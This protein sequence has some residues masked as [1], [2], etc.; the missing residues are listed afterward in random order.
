MNVI[1]TDLEEE[2]KEYQISY[3]FNNYFQD[4]TPSSS[5]NPNNNPAISN[6]NPTTSTHY[7]SNTV[8]TSLTSNVFPTDHS[9][10]HKKV[11]KKKRKK[12]KRMSSEEEEP[13]LL[14]KIDNSILNNIGEWRNSSAAVRVH[15]RNFLSPQ[16]QQSPIDVEHLPHLFKSYHSVINTNTSI[17][18][19]VKD[20]KPRNTDSNSIL[21]EAKRTL[22]NLQPP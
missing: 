20:V 8:S 18:T 15:H 17:N 21:Q 11:K 19:P 2:D 14:S 9:F 22:M 6:N 5:F 10:H 7:N 12:F 16:P 4:N 1:I 3:D 13:S